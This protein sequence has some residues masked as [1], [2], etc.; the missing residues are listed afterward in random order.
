[1]SGITWWRWLYFRLFGPAPHNKLNRGI[2]AEVT[3]VLGEHGHVGMHWS[4]LDPEDDPSL[5]YGYMMNRWL[6]RLSEQH[7][8]LDFCTQDG[9]VIPLVRPTVL[10]IRPT[11]H[12]SEKNSPLPVGSETKVRATET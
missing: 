6:T 2:R 4:K 9:T 3:I 5:V 7:V 1:M 8:S 10:P 11:E 12:L